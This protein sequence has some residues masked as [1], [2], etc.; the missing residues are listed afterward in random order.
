MTGRLPGHALRSQ[1]A[2]YSEKGREISGSRGIARCEC[3]ATSAV[4]DSTA[5]RK[6]WHREH[7]SLIARETPE[8]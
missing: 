5:E 7:K 1:G 8:R 4:L 3:G 2:P 6:R